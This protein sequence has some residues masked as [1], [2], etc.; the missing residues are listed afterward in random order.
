MK[1]PH[2]TDFIFKMLL[3]N[4]LL[5]LDKQDRK[6]YRKRIRKIQKDGEK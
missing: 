3:L 1:K 6:K 2:T 4:P 5:D